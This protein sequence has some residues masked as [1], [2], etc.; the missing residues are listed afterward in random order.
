MKKYTIN[1]EEIGVIQD[2]DKAAVKW[3]KKSMD[4]AFNPEIR[5]IALATVDTVLRG[6]GLSTQQKMVVLSTLMAQYA[7]A[8]LASEQAD[9][10]LW[11]DEKGE[12]HTPDRGHT[13]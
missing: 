12:E 2:R 8:M 6:M 7:I 4:K 5:Q 9:V 10:S 11:L 1:G 3:I 13:S